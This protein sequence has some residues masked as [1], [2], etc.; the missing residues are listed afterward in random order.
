MSKDHTQGTRSVC[1]G[2]GRGV[3]LDDVIRSSFALHLISF[4]PCLVRLS[5][6]D[7]AEA[8]NR[9]GCLASC[10]LRSNDARTTYRQPGTAADF[11]DEFDKKRV[12]IT[13][14]STSILFLIVQQTAEPKKSNGR[15]LEE[16]K[17]KESARYAE[18]KP[19]V[20]SSLNR[21]SATVS[22]DFGAFFCFYE[23]SA[24][25]RIRVTCRDIWNI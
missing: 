9:E 11:L 5:T 2:D 23:K 14:S 12:Q 3:H 24:D 13:R 1:K 4:H 15:S 20:R 21:R 17:R 16:L 25:T 8:E 22:V 6:L 19:A 18:A 10:P 7:R